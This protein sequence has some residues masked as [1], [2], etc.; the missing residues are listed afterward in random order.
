MEKWNELW[1]E[2]C[3]ILSENLPTNTNEQL[4]EKEVVRAFEKLGWSEYNKEISVRESIQIGSSNRRIAPDL[5]LRS[6]DE[7][8]LF[9]V[10][11]KK[12]S[13]EIDNS[14]FKGQLSSY[15]RMVRVTEGILIGNK[16]QLFSDDE[17]LNKDGIDLIVEIEFKRDNEKGLKFVELFSKENYSKENIEEY[18][19][20]KKR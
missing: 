11:V 17:S 20:E 10:E 15:M 1:N 2:L 16:I 8:N 18:I 14:T 9:V 7:G 19:Q 4:F 13:L 6:K 3:Y 12:P 5:I